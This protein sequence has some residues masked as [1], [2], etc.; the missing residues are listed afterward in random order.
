MLISK[1]ALVI[2]YER[3][4]VQQTLIRVFVSFFENLTFPL[5][6]HIVVVSYFCRK[7]V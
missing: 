5:D 3:S 2:I 6:G 4:H 1:K 7:D